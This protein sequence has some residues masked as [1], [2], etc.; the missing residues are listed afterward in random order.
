MND[1]DAALPRSP[2]LR[3]TQGEGVSTY[4]LSL[5]RLQKSQSYINCRVSH[6]ESAEGANESTLLCSEPG[7]G[8]L[9]READLRAEPDATGAYL[10]QPQD[11]RLRRFGAQRQKP[12]GTAYG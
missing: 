3:E 6:S 12:K 11:S 10:T 1:K 4:R 7:T 8:G 2:Q 5:L 9:T